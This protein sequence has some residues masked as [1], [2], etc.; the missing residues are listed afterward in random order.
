MLFFFTEVG[1]KHHLLDHSCYISFAEVGGKPQL[2]DHSCYI[3]LARSWG[4]APISGLFILY[5]L[6]QKLEASP[7][8]WIINVLYL[9]AEVWDKFPFKVILDIFHLLEAGGEP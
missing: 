4:H 2:L 8:S 5:F 1:V 9:L 7:T 6:C 3:S